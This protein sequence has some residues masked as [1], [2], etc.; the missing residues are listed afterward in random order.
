MPRLLFQSTHPHG[1]RHRN[2]PIN[3]MVGTVSIHAPTWGATLGCASA[4]LCRKV[5]IHAPTWGATILSLFMLL[6]LLVSIHAPTWGATLGDYYDFVEIT[7]F[8]PRTHM[9][10]DSLRLGR[11]KG[12]LEFQSTHPHGVRLSHRHMFTAQIG[13]SIHAPTWGAT[14]SSY[15]VLNVIRVSIHAPTW[16]ATL[17]SA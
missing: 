8:N 5:S 13:V 16:G 4:V 1:V 17:A 15:K 11:R 3:Y 6:V 10:C 7:S 14:P 12:G 9:G 2:K